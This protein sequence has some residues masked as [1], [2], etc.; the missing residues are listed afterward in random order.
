MCWK[1]TCRSLVEIEV[2]RTLESAGVVF[3]VVMIL[4]VEIWRREN[5]RQEIGLALG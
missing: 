2:V 5:V 1:R 3:L 4:D